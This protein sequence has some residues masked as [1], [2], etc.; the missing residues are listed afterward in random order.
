MNAFCHVAQ[1]WTAGE[2]RSKMMTRTARRT[3]A[4]VLLESL[5]KTLQDTAEAHDEI[6]SQQ[7]LWAMWRVG[8]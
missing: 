1:A 4:E 7:K 8:R 2:L 3:Y 5:E 6:I